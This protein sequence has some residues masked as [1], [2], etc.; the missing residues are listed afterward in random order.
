MEKGDIVEERGEGGRFGDDD[1]G[2]EDQSRRG[3]E[4]GGKLLSA[5]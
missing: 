1:G 3:G 4:E 5:C 2:K